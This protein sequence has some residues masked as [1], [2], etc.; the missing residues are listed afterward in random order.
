MG[1]MDMLRGNAT[2]AD[3]ARVQ[4]ELQPILI[5]G[6]IVERAFVFVRDQIVFTDRRLIFVNKQG[7]TGKKVDWRSIPYSK[8]TSFSAETAGF[9]DTDAEL[10]IWVGSAQEPIKVE[11][12]KGVPIQDVYQVLSWHVL[13]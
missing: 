11:I 7:M 9:M 13:T 12:S 10:R 8:I 2:A 4:Q 5:K 1:I 3:P 6:E